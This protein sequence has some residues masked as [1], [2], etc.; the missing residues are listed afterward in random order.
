MMVVVQ[1][2]KV[3]AKPLLLYAG[4]VEVVVLFCLVIPQNAETGR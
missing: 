1:N 2:I 4:L 3:A